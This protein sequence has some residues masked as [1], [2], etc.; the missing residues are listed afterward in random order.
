[1]IKQLVL[2]II[3]NRKFIA[4]FKSLLYLF[5]GIVIMSCSS[6]KSSEKI[7][8]NP[9]PKLGA[10]IVE[11]YWKLIEIN[12]HREGST[13]EGAKEAHMI[14]SAKD[15][16]IHGNGGCNSYS[17]TYEISEG[18]RIKFSQIATTK[19][20]C[21]HHHHEDEFFR[22]LGEVDNYSIQDDILSL[23][24]ARMA[25]MAKLQVVYMKK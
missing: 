10:E 4:M 6:T 24:K 1:M 17:G 20:A 3:V 5:F 14:L 2:T 7:T 23:N 15:N 18:N 25:P 9:T 11:K 21:M 8:E 22:I 12:G 16:R 19:M 13:V